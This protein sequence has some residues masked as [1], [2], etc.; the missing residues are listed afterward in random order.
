MTKYEIQH[1]LDVL[2]ELIRGLLLN[3]EP[4]PEA[5]I[6]EKNQLLKAFRSM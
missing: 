1:R 6:H 2:H 5:L 4:V 3:E